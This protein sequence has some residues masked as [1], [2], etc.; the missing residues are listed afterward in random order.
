MFETEEARATLYTTVGTTRLHISFHQPPL[1][2]INF[3]PVATIELDF[4]AQEEASLM[5]IKLKDMKDTLL[6][7]QRSLGCLSTTEPGPVS[8]RHV[9]T[10]GPQSIRESFL[11]VLRPD[12]FILIPSR[13]KDVLE[14]SGVEQLCI[15][16]LTGLPRQH[17][18]QLFC[19][20]SIDLKILQISFFKY[21]MACLQL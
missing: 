7:T 1:N 17:S 8:S 20:Y 3:F 13:Y 6:H 9:T 14:R 19:S 16:K 11:A 10:L 18:Q 21:A 2:Q 4:M 5:E 15:Y 12:S